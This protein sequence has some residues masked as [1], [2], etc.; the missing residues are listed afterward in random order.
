MALPFEVPC[1]VDVWTPVF[2]FATPGDVS[3]SYATQTGRLAK[4]GR[5]IILDFELTCTPTFTTASGAALITGS[6][7]APAA[8]GKGTCLYSGVTKA[9]YTHV[10]SRIGAVAAQTIDFPCS[11]SGLGIAAIQATDLVSAAPV[12]FRGCIVFITA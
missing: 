6:P 11:G 4:I 8:T 9:G 10:V 1:P 5:L 2:T 3:V 7:Y 12:I